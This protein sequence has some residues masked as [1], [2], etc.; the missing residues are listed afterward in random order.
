M[1]RNV[2]LSVLIVV[3]V[4]WAGWEL[5][6]TEHGPVASETAGNREAGAAQAEQSKERTHGG[7]WFEQGGFA[8]EL[9]LYE[10]GVPPE[11]HVYAY[12]NAKQLPPD[13]VDVDIQL[14]RSDGQ[15]DRFAFTPLNDYLRGDGVVTEPH[16]FDV[17]I[18]A[19]YQGQ[20]YRW[21]FA[22]YEGRTEIP[23]VLAREAGIET[24]VAGPATVTE[25]LQLTGRVQADPARVAQMR[26]RFPGLVMDVGAE[27]GQWV[28]RGDV[29]ARIQS[30]ESLQTY[31]LKSPIDG[32]VLERALNVGAPTGDGPLFVIADLSKVWVELDVFSRD[33]DRIEP[34]QDVSIETL[35]GRRVD[36]AVFYVSPMAAHTSQTVR[37]RVELDNGDKRLRPGQFV[38]AQVVVAE[39]DVALAVRQSAIQGFRDFQVVFAR[40]GDLYEVRMLELGRQNDEWA[41]VLDGL[42][43]GTEYVTANSYLIKADVEKS[44]ASHDH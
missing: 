44:G 3:G 9:V 32:I 17:A 26:A 11:F 21:E 12:E 39:H 29:L 38:R 24:A 36:G 2:I 35:D 19:R 37:A 40:Y 43:P 27:I 1:I 20:T 14:T 10:T 41:E 22:S 13:S 33:I 6:R 7:K 16:S 18:A 8:L 30:N 42:K 28:Q 31:A 4:L 23:Q 25:K 15:V 5:L 34:G